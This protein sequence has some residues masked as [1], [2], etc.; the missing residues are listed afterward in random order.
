MAELH[1]YKLTERKLKLSLAKIDPPKRVFFYQRRDGSIFSCHQT[2]AW[3]VHMFYMTYGGFVGSSDGNAYR[4]VL[5][6]AC[7]VQDEALLILDRKRR[8][9][10]MKLKRLERKRTLT[11]KEEKEMDEFLDIQE[12]YE[13]KLDAILLESRNAITRAWNAEL[14]VARGNFIGPEDDSFIGGGTAMGSDGRIL[15]T[16][17]FNKLP[18]TGGIQ[19]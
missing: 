16:K 11:K 6:E 3:N 15:T 10:E 14:E 8:E 7:K 18:G 5:I 4:N 13:E 1:D 2:E 12:N 19:T 17:Q 9:A